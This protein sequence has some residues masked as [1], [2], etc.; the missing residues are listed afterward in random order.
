MDKAP[1]K[2]HHAEVLAEKR[3]IIES[4]TQ[5]LL[6]I[7]REGQF[8]FRCVDCLFDSKICLRSFITP[9]IV[10]GEIAEELGMFCY[11]FNMNFRGFYFI[12]ILW[13]YRS[14]R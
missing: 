13:Y 2:I 9:C 3:Q 6:V 7:Q 10:N 12:L 5:R 1:K 11:N 8:T 14:R 4:D